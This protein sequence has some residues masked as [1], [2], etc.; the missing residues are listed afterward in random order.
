MST[1][2]TIRAS[3]HRSP[4]AHRGG[5]WATFVHRY[6]W[7]AYALPILS[8]VTVAALIHADP[9]GNSARTYPVADVAAG[10]TGTSSPAREQTNSTDVA[11]KQVKVEGL[12]GAAAGFDAG[13]TPPP[14]VVNLGDDAVSCAS[15]TYRQLL[16]VSISKQHL[17]ACEGGKQVNSSAVTTGATVDHDQTPLGSWRVQAKQR[18]RYLVGAGYRDYVHYWVPFNGD[19]GLHDAPWQTMASGSRDY[20][21]KGSHG[22]VHV[23]TR[24][25][26]W[27]YR[28]TSVN[29]TVVTVEA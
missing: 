5:R 13:A 10:Q 25:M 11:S 22:C 2:Q 20:T 18:D 1:D 19:F 6:G 26:A 15:N 3:A 9:S 14:V 7:R 12:S 29:N 23:P 8:A 27:L 28:W 4:A 16:L 21:Q 17:W 24:T